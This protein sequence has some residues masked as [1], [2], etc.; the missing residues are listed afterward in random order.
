MPTRIEL[1]IVWLRA[2][3]NDAILFADAQA[4]AQSL[5]ITIHSGLVADALRDAGFYFVCGSTELICKRYEETAS[6]IIP[7]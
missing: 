7:A 1:L 6:D 5:G 3:K 4:H 2:H